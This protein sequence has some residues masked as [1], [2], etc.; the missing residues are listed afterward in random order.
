M[1][2]KFRIRIKTLSRRNKQFQENKRLG[3]LKHKTYQ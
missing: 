2:L 3:N 1:P